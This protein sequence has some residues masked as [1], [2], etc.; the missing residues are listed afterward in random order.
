MKSW[1]IATGLAVAAALAAP[2]AL[3]TW[4]PR[5]NAERWIALDAQERENLLAE[6]DRSKNCRFYETQVEAR[7]ALGLTVDQDDVRQALLCHR[8]QDALQDGGRVEAYFSRSR[9]VE[10]NVLVALAGFAAAFALG[11]TL[12]GALRRYRRQPGT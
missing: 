4:Q 10:R 1:K 3:G 8:R 6:M 9:Y 2:F 5:A 11:A 12:S 7:D